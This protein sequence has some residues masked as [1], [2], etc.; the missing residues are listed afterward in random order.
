MMKNQARELDVDV[1]G[2]RRYSYSDHGF[3][4]MW[5]R[6]REFITLGEVHNA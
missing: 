2:G 4:P 5:G 6:E 3:H 1:A